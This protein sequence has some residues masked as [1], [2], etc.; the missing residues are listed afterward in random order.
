VLGQLV[1][2]SHC[3]SSCCSRAAVV[4]AACQRGASSAAERGAGTID[5]TSQHVS[6]VALSRRRRRRATP[7]GGWARAPCRARQRPPG[8]KRSS[9]RLRAQHAG[10][11][12][13]RL[14][15]AAARAGCAAGRNAAGCHAALFAPCLAARR[16]LALIGRG[17][18]SHP[19]APQR[20]HMRAGGRAGPAAHQR[21]THR[22]L[23]PHPRAVLP[24]GER[25]GAERRA[26]AGCC[27][28]AVPPRAPACIARPVNARRS[29][30]RCAPAARARRGRT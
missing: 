11:H 19:R 6:V 15:G 16:S 28:W 25:G 23:C 2:T 4:G 17:K 18:A 24:Q 14:V 27:A 29:R 9:A 20:K 1:A 21:A 5:G 13:A 10:R 30:P 12:P 26:Q 7:H 3:C 8:A 22:L